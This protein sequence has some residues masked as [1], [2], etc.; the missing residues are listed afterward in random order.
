MVAARENELCAP[1]ILTT[2]GARQR[3][4]P[5][6]YFDLVCS[7]FLSTADLR[8]NAKQ[9]EHVLLYKQKKIKIERREGKTYIVKV[10]YIYW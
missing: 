8:T 7:L 3:G 2:A 9:N 1:G 10:L 6:R 4:S 5:A